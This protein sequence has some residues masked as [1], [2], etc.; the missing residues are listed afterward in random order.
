MAKRWIVKRGGKRSAPIASE[1][2]IALAKEGKVLRDDMICPEGQDNWQ[3]ASSVKG[4]FSDDPSAA[5][6][7]PPVIKKQQVPEATFSQRAEV[8]DYSPPPAARR[9][10]LASK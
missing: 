10:P 6:P 3:R 8:V 2:L 7:S 1:K 9:P 4:L 5:R